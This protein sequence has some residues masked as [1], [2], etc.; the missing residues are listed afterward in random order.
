[1]AGRVVPRWDLAM[2]LSARDVERISALL[3]RY[4]VGLPTQMTVIPAQ[5]SGEELRYHNMLLC[6]TESHYL[7]VL[8][9][10]QACRGHF[11]SGR[12]I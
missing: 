6:H 1:M 11:S 3:V 5:K 4:W 9:Q 8:R 7:T 12:L 10:S 2:H